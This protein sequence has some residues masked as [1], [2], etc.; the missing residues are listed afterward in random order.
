M[1][2]FNPAQLKRVFNEPSVRPQPRNKENN[3]DSKPT[4]LKTNDRHQGSGF[5]NTP[6]RIDTSGGFPKRFNL[7]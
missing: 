1:E 7:S 2:T 3:D 6:E 5:K 4:A